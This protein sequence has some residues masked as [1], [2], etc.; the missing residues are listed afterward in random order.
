MLAGSAAN[1]LHM[2]G[3]A[4]DIADDDGVLRKWCADHLGDLTDI[5]L[6]MEDPRTTPTWLHVQTKPP[7]S[8][9]VV[10]IPNADWARRLA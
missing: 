4:V 5:G 7:A 10:F 9:H 3:Q 6:Y 1:S 2:S 8:G